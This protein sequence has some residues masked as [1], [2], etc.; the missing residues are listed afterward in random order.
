MF[1]D[2]L[3]QLIKGYS[4]PFLMV[5]GFV[6][7]NIMILWS[8]KLFIHVIMCEKTLVVVRNSTEAVHIH[9]DRGAVR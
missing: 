9:I 5:V 2:I 1:V 6:Q 8:Y 3:Y 4:D 7:Q